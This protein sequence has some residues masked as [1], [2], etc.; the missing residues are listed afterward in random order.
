[1]LGLAAKFDD[2]YDQITIYKIK[3]FEVADPF[4]ISVWVL[5]EQ[6]V[7]K[8][9]TMT[10]IGNSSIKDQFWRG[11]DLVIES[12]GQVSSRFVSSLP[13]N[14]IHT[15]TNDSIPIGKWTHLLMTYDGSTKASGLKIYINGQTTDTEIMYDRLYKSVVP[16]LNIQECYG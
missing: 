13:G 10:I 2:Q 12:T 8:G 3:G 4:S 1:M 5:P 14:Y 11:W 6:K 16:E 9:K 15:M 7:S